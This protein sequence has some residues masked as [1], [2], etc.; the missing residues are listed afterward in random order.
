MDGRQGA[1]DAG[2]PREIDARSEGLTYAF[3]PPI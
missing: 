3:R 1:A 2:A